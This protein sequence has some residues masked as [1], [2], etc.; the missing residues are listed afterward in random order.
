[1]GTARLE[2]VYSHD[3]AGRAVDFPLTISNNVFA[4]T[5]AIALGATFLI[6]VIP[7]ILAGKTDVVIA[8]KDESGSGGGR[9]SRARL[10]LVTAQVAASVM[11]LVGAALLLQS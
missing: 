9:R 4:A 1:G 2:S 10:V 3:G 11:L 7:S 8:L 5:A 6:G